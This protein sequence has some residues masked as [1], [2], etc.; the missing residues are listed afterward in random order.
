MRILPVA[1]L[2]CAVTV[3]VVAGCPGGGPAG[4][5]LVPVSGTI[6]LDDKPLPDAS[7]SFGGISHGSTDANGH[8]E[9]TY[10]GKD[11]GVPVGEYT[12]TCEKWVMEDG[13]LYKGEMSPMMANAKP[14]LLPKYSDLAQSELKATVAAGGG[15]FDFKLSSK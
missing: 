1:L 5:D 13:S 10:Q 12:V 3:L 15:T 14:L 7:V 2:T 11:K 4:P 9:L 8:Y 6:T